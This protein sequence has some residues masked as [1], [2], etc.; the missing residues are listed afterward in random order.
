MVGRILRECNACCTAPPTGLELLG[1]PRERAAFHGFGCRRKPGPT[2]RNCLLLA[3]NALHR[4]E[5]GRECQCDLCDHLRDDAPTDICSERRFDINTDPLPD[6][7]SALQDA[8]Q[9]V[10]VVAGVNAGGS[11]LRCEPFTWACI[12]YMSPLVS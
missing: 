10:L 1:T 11:L 3:L 2:C 6:I 9:R 4:E 5:V 8:L 12:R 7:C